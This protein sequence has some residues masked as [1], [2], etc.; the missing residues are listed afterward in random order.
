VAG[1]HRQRAVWLYQKAIPSAT[2][3][4]HLAAREAVPALASSGR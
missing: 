3:R 4:R 1:E 2:G